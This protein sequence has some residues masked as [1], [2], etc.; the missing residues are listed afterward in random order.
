MLTYGSMNGVRTADTSLL[1][2]RDI[3][4]KI[5]ERKTKMLKYCSI[6]GVSTANTF[7]LPVRD[8]EVKIFRAKNETF[9]KLFRKPH[10]HHRHLPFTSATSKKSIY[11]IKIYRTEKQKCSNTVQ[12][13]AFAP[14]TLSFHL[15]DFKYR[16]IE[17]IFLYRKTKMLV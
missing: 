16:D 12:E 17:D 1:P 5:L 7:L 4:V 15:C 8:I 11:R 13:T 14:L 9:R 2:V 3:E 10:L 6:N